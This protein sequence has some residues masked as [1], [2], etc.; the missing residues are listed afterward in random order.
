MILA[1]PPRSPYDLHFNVFGVPVRIH[2]MFWLVSLLLGANLKEPALVLMWV[3]VAFAS[4]LIHELGHVVAYR[5][6]GMPAE[7]VLYSFGGLAISRGYRWPSYVG[8]MIISFAGPAAGFIAAGLIFACLQA[9]QVPFLVKFGL[10][11]IVNYGVQPFEPIN[12]YYLVVLLLQINLY[13]GLVNLLPIYPLDG[14]Q[15][16]RALFEHFHVPDAV[17]KSLLLSIIAA[18][19]MV[20]IALRQEDTFLAVMF[21]YLAYQ[22]YQLM[23]QNQG[24]F[25]RSPW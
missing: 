23:Q 7:V 18:G 15:I 17:H 22:N 2:P 25:N 21:G 16:S 24:R 19:T 4:I 20:L 6:F 12:L 3:G 9:A 10:P 13:W 11:M 1:E 14:G 8:Q 5:Y